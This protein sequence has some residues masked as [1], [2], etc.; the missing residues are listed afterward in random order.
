MKTVT[1]CG[2]RKFKPEMRAFAQ[3]LSLGFVETHEEV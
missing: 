3:V 2:S 1:L